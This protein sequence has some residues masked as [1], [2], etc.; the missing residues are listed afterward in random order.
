MQ[1]PDPFCH[2]A[3]L[4]RHSCSGGFGCHQQMRNTPHGVS[5][6]REGIAKGM[7]LRRI[8]DRCAEREG[9]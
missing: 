9:R 8:R 4:V 6:P 3:L 1:R 7:S 5:M 2:E